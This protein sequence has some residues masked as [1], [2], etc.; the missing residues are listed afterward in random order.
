MRACLV[1]GRRFVGIGLFLVAVGASVMAEAPSADNL[2]EIALG[3][4]PLLHVERAAA[5][6]GI[7]G[8]AMLVVWRAGRGEF[9][10]RFAQI[11]YETRSIA[12]EM[13]QA[14]GL[15]ELRIDE[16][17]KATQEDGD[18]PVADAAEEG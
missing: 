10:I 11:E 18:R 12:T 4:E 17:E 2:P 7:A 13:D 3:W 15:L 1:L 5:A 9:P 16:L 14:I 8:F 6:V